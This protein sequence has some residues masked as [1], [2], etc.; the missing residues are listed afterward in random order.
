[1]SDS[2]YRVV[3]DYVTSESEFEDEVQESNKKKRT[4]KNWIYERT[5]DDQEASKDW[6][7]NEKIW[8]SLKISKNEAGLRVD[9]RCNLVK[10]KGLQC[11]AAIYLL[12]KSENLSVALFKTKD[13]HNHDEIAN[14]GHGINKETF[15][16]R[17]KSKWIARRY[18][19]RQI[20]KYKLR[21]K[22]Q[23][24][25]RILFLLFRDNLIYKIKSG[26]SF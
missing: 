22:N 26:K 12:Y 4:R 3:D 10:R 18:F 21:R 16:H 25:F 23:R 7:D 17:I 11:A 24:K 15:Y 5:S 20:N 2:E 13:Q 9:Y 6:L 1:M 14:T 19:K 8:S